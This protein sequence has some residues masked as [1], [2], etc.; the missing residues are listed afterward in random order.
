MKYGNTTVWRLTCELFDFLPLAAVVG[1]QVFAVHGGLSPAISLVSQIQ[2]IDRFKEIPPEGPMADLMWSDPE[3]SLSSHWLQNP[4][5]AGWI[6]GASPTR[7]FLHL[8]NLSLV[9]RGHQLVN[10][11]FKYMFT[12]PLD[13]Q[14]IPGS[15][16]G[17]LVTVWSAP[18]YC[19]R[20]GNIASI[21]AIDQQGKREFKVFTDNHTVPPAPKDV[22]P[23]FV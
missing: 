8:N 12:S 10:E 6:F 1:N 23:Y 22:V 20:C 18:N 7:E 3:E 16:E 13:L 5:G 15:D 4:R 14:Q 9:A 21:L 17:L 2:L 11:G 19:Y